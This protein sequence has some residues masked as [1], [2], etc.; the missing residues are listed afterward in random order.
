MSDDSNDYDNGAT[1]YTTDDSR[2]DHPHWWSPGA[3]RFFSTRVCWT[4]ETPVTLADGTEGVAF[5]T[6]EAPPN[7]GRVYSIRLHTPSGCLTIDDKGQRAGL[8]GGWRS[9]SGAVAGL[10]RWIKAGCPIRG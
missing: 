6:S 9:R 5:I 10:R 7:G 8:L 2:N 4:T 1:M 3:L